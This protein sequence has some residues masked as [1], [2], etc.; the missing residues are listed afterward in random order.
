[1]DL[2]LDERLKPAKASA[3][4]AKL[5]GNSMESQTV[6]S[7]VSEDKHLERN[8]GG[9]S[10]NHEKHDDEGQFE[11][12]VWKQYKAQPGSLGGQ[13]VPTKSSTRI[14]SR[15]GTRD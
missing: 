4:R 13:I 9:E 6:T 12:P 3:E 1:M 5:E 11:E 7:T 15:G 10:R 8:R 14:D 2:T